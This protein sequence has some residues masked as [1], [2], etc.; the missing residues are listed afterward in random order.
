MSEQLTPWYELLLGVVGFLAIL[1][2]PVG[3]V[4]WYLRLF[5]GPPNGGSSP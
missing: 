4:Y 5:G 1:L 3:G 2:V